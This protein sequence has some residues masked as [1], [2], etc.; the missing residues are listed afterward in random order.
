[1]TQWMEK[2]ERAQAALAKM[3][4]HARS[5]IPKVR[6]DAEAVVAGTLAGAI[7]GAFEA[8]GKD[9]SLPGPGGMKIP[10]ELPIGGL[11]LA[12][13]FSGQTEVSDDLHAAG[14][15]VLAYSGGR[16]AENYFR[17]RRKAD[18]AAPGVPQ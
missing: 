11:L 14:S 5:V 15:G 6:H 1:M 7:R 8:T 3:R 10:P 12:L 4:E 17:L 9:Y 2:A 18:T 13:A 16:E